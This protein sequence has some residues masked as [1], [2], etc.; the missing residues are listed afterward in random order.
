MELNVSEVRRQLLTLVE[1]L[2]D[3]GV[4]ITKRGKP[5]ARITPFKPPRPRGEYVTGPLI[6]TKGGVGPD[7]PTTENPYDVLFG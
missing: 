2:P 1:R 6:K 7:C 3:E 4:I 5:V